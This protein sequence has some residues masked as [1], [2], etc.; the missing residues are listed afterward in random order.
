MLKG[1][2]LLDA[3]PLKIGIR[4]GVGHVLVKSKV[5]SDVIPKATL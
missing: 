5:R 2:V 1:N 3:E 4:W